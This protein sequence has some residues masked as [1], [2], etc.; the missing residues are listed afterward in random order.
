MTFLMLFPPHEFVTHGEALITS[1]YMIN[2]GFLHP[3]LWSFCLATSVDSTLII[4][5]HCIVTLI[6]TSVVCR[7][8]GKLLLRSSPTFRDA[9]WIIQC[10]NRHGCPYSAQYSQ[11]HLWVIGKQCNTITIIFRVHWR[12]QH[13]CYRLGNCFWVDHM[14]R[15]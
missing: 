3:L 10:L 13:T 5:W 2:L 7:M 11:H 9:R 12:R 14:W 8:H 1:S 4:K 15:K 6:T